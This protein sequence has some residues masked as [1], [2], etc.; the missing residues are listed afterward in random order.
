MS[1]ILVFSF[2]LYPDMPDIEEIKIEFLLYLTSFMSDRERKT[3]RQ[4]VREI[5][6]KRNRDSNY[7]IKIIKIIL[8]I[9]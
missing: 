1:L 5:E 4:R 9:F 8:S 6:I 7:N 2:P 3:D